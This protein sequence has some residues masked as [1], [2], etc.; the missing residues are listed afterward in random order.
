MQKKQILLTED[1][2]VQELA[3]S[4]DAWQFTRTGIKIM[5][6]ELAFDHMQSSSDCSKPPPSLWFNIPEEAIK[7]ISTEDV[8]RITRKEKDLKSKVQ[9]GK[10]AVRLQGKGLSKDICFSYSSL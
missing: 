4:R 5:V 2:G 1:G 10:Q 3:S 9:G 7:K 6:H 8:K